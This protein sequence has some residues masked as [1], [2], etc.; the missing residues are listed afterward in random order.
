MATSTRRPRP[1]TCGEPPP[2]DV[3]ELHER[4]VAGDPQRREPGPRR[5]DGTPA[6]GRNAG[7]SRVRQDAPARRRPRHD[8]ARRRLLLPGQPGQR[9]DVLGERRC[10]AWSRGWASDAIGWGTQLKTF[11][12]RL[13]AQLGIPAEVRDAVAGDAPLTRAQLDTFIRALR[14]VRRDVGRRCQD[15]ARAL[16][17]HGAADFEAQDVG[18]AHL[19]SDPG[20]PAARAE[21]GLS[22]QLREPAADRPRHLPAHGADAQP[23]GHRR[24]PARHAVRPDQHR[25]SSSST[26]AW[27]TAAAMALGPVA[28]GLL[29]LARHHPP[30]ARGRVLPA[31]HLGAADEER[32]HARSS[33]GSGGRPARPDPNARRSAQAI[34]AKRFTA[35]FDDEHFSAPYPTW[36]IRPEAFADAEAALTPRA[37]LRRVDP[38]MRR[39]LDQRRWSPSCDRLVDDVHGATRADRTPSGRRDNAHRWTQRFAELV[40]AAD[41]R[42]ALDPA[43]RTSTCPRCSSAGLAAWIDEQAPTGRTYKIEPQRGK[44]PALHGRLIEVL[45]EATENEARL[46]LSCHR[47]RQRDGGNQPDQGCV[48]KGGLRSTDAAA[49]PRRAPQR[50]RGHRGPAPKRSPTR[51]WRPAAYVHQITEEDLK[52]F[53]ALRDMQSRPDPHLQEWLADSEA[54]D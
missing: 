47:E 12:R 44:K 37:L 25:R 21:W 26:R 31:G 32:A 39:C 53:A 20:D 36:P 13:T 3:P 27:R 7:P 10:L 50:A 28:D 43:T 42:A 14:S 48:H 35:A 38:H 17:L 1:T 29:T 2:F 40:A 5:D 11:L 16:V 24:R 51:S 54:R 8:P 45:D 23:D 22:R 19:I 49:P 52:V 4:V 9:Q 41:V 34:I 30:H 18:Y 15:T 6:R 33:T 46:E